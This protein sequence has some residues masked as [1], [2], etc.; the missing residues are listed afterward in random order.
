MP[1]QVFGQDEIEKVLIA[2]PELRF[3]TTYLSNKYRKYAVNGETIQDK[4]TGEIFTRRPE[5]GRVVSFYQNKKYM[6]D[7]MLELKIL[8]NSNTSFT[9]PQESDINAFYVSTDYDLMTINDDN[10]V[11]M[12]EGDYIIPSDEQDKH[13]ILFRISTT[14]NGFFCR[15]T[16]RDADKVVINWLTNLYDTT[17]KNYTGTDRDYLNEKEKFVKNPE[18]DDCNCTLNYTVTVEKSDGTITSNTVD[19]YIHFNEEHS[20]M[21]PESIVE[22]Y[23]NS[24]DCT[25]TIRI[26]K[27]SYP[28]EQF[29]LSH[30]TTEMKEEYNKY[31]YPDNK[32]LS[33]Y[34]NII[35]FVDK[36][37]DVLSNNN[38]FII[39]M[40]D[41]PYCIKYLR[42]IASLIDPSSNKMVLSPRRPSA[43]KWTD[44]SIWAEEVRNVYAGGVIVNR[45]SETEIKVLERIISNVT[46]D[47]VD[48]FDTIY[49]EGPVVPTG[50]ISVDNDYVVSD[51]AGGVILILNKGNMAVYKETL[52]GLYDA[53]IV[54]E[55]DGGE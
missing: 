27:L 13:N 51:E 48:P 40:I 12:L 55:N 17:I 7:L 19:D 3:A 10:E 44:G 46:M 39:A 33:T 41:A 16:S 6:Y 32:I 47:T 34:L 22:K 31:V 49:K 20:V 8:L 23:I 30:M 52:P 37:T 42:K 53:I 25:V 54:P 14:C 29:I 2:K 50:Y 45:D 26:N 11:D 4:A 9:H 38:E 15:L 24:N 28:K 18:W 36:S 21:I 1:V 43:E 35:S 5:D